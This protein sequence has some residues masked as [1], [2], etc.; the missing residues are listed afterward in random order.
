VT[1]PTL[2]VLTVCGR[3]DE[4]GLCEWRSCVYPAEETAR[5]LE[6][7]SA[8]GGVAFARHLVEARVIALLAELGCGRCP[9]GCEK[10]IHAAVEAFD[11]APASRRWGQS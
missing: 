9:C 1:A 11:R 8:A 5:R 10:A 6:T 3:P 4:F 7:V 2:Y